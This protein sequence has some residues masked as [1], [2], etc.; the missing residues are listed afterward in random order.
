MRLLAIRDIGYYSYSCHRLRLTGD[1]LFVT[2]GIDR[3]AAK[4]S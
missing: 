2:Q 1:D 3:G 4:R